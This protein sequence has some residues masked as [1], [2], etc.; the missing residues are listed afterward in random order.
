MSDSVQV[1]FKCPR[2]RTTLEW[3]DDAVDSTKIACTN[4]GEDCGTYGDL[5]NRA[6]EATKAHIQR[7][8]KD[9]LKPIKIELKF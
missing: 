2:C 3:P 1:S 6:V 9:A 4:C 7:L 5:S 8:M